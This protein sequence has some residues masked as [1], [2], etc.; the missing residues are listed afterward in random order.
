MDDIYP[1]SK[2]L[3]PLIFFTCGEDTISVP[4]IVCGTIWGSFPVLGSFAIQFGDHL[5]YWDHL[6]ARTVLQ[7]PASAYQSSQWGEANLA[8]E[9]SREYSCEYSRIRRLTL[10]SSPHKF[11]KVFLQKG[12]IC[13]TFHLLEFI[14]GYRPVTF[15]VLGMDTGDCIHEVDW[16]I[17][18]LVIETQGP[19]HSSVSRPFNCVNQRAWLYLSL[20]NRQKR[21]SISP[22]DKL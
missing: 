2:F 7:C 15:C 5:R 16:V 18:R 19:L 6:R 13:V 22:S 10:P 14:F 12:W 17:H 3:S 11:F 8:C 21:G 1:L 20:N 9:Y 4:G